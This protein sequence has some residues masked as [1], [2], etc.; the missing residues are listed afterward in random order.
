MYPSFEYDVDGRPAIDAWKFR[1]ERAG[2][3]V[4]FNGGQPTQIERE[5]GHHFMVGFN[6]VLANNPH[7]RR[8]EDDE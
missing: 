5:Y 1:E 4:A 6:T 2:A 7:L 3:N 8:S